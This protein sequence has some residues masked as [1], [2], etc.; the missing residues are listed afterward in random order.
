MKSTWFNSLYQEYQ[1]A[2]TDLRTKYK[3]QLIQEIIYN[4]KTDDNKLVKIFQDIAAENTALAEKAIPELK[5]QY[6]NDAA[7][8]YQ[9]VLKFIPGNLETYKKIEQIHSAMVKLCNG[10]INQLISI[11]SQS[12]LDK[13]SHKSKL[14][15]L[16]EETRTSFKQIESYKNAGNEEL[17][18]NKSAELFKEIARKMEQ[19]LGGLYQSAENMLDAVPCKYAVIGLG[20][21]ALRQMTP[22]SDLECAIL[23]SEDDP[24]H[25]EYFRN[26]SQL[27]HFMVINL[28]ETVI[29]TSRYGIDLGKFIPQAVN[30]DL[31]GKT[32]LG[33]LEKDKPYELIQTVEEM[34]KYLKNDGNK[35]EHIDKNLAAV[36]QKVCFIYGEKSLVENYQTKVKEFLLLPDESGKLNCESRAIKALWEGVEELDYT[37]SSPLPK[38]IEGNLKQFGFEPHEATGKLFDVKQEIYRL[39]DRL[40]YNLGLLYGIQEESSWDTI[41]KLCELGKISPG[42]LVNLKKALTFATNLRLKTYDHYGCQKE[43]I[44]FSNAYNTPNP[45]SEESRAALIKTF[46]LADYDLLPDGSLFEY[47]YTI[48]PFH[49]ELVQYCEDRNPLNFINKGFYEKSNKTKAEVYHRLGQL[50]ASLECRKSY[51][52]ELKENGQAISKEMV[53]TLYKIGMLHI[54][55]SKPRPASDSFEEALKMSCVLPG[56]KYK[57]YASLQNSFGTAKYLLGDYSNALKHHT[58]ALT[59]HQK[60]LGSNHAKIAEIYNNIGLCHLRLREHE[61]CIKAFNDAYRIFNNCKDVTGEAKTLD[62]IGVYYR[63]VGQYKEALDTH[64]K[65]LKIYEEIYSKPMCATVLFNL[66][67]DYDKLSNFKDAL[68]YKFRAVNL[69]KTLKGKI[70]DIAI[71]KALIADTYN[72]LGNYQKELK[73]RKE[74]LD[75]FEKHHKE[76]DLLTLEYKKEIICMYAFLGKYSKALTKVKE[77]LSFAQ[78]TPDKNSALI[79][80]CRNVMVNL[81]NKNN[82]YNQAKNALLEAEQVLEGIEQQSKMAAKSLFDKALSRLEQSTELFKESPDVLKLKALELLIKVYNGIGNAKN[83]EALATAEAE[84]KKL[85]TVIRDRE[86]KIKEVEEYIAL[87]FPSND[88]PKKAVDCLRIVSYNITVDFFDDRDKTADKHHHWQFRKPIVI[89]LLKTVYPDVICLQEL[90]PN[91]ALELHQYFDIKLGYSSVFLSQTPSEIPVGE[92]VSGNNVRQWCGKNIGTPLVGTFIGNNY[93]FLDTGRFWLNE[94]PDKLPEYFDR[95]ATDKGFGNMNTYRAVLWTKIEA[96]TNKIIFVFNSHYPLSGDSRTRLECVKL[97]MQKIKD[98]THGGNWISAGDRNIIP[99]NNDNELSNPSV[100][101]QELTKDAKNVKCKHYGI[102]TTWLGFSYDQYPAQVKDGTVESNA[103][104][105]VIASNLQQNSTFFLHGAFDPVDHNL[106]PLL[107]ALEVEQNTGRYFA[108]DHALAGADLLLE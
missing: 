102:N 15:V 22:Y 38:K 89:K 7:A 8:A 32:P 5:L 83:K 56:N 48:L 31:G 60:L 85:V 49:K 14:Q 30:F 68:Y 67:I 66:G 51:K 55:L 46:Q 33:R 1:K 99:T 35:S 10:S 4:T 73:Y 24:K 70:E 18:V 74:V 20:S 43:T 103:I 80:E 61:L 86:A 41:D 104:L 79:S 3:E 65:A 16:R 62:N 88:L 42:G 69:A 75:F 27:V 9:Y 84:Y 37:K 40:I 76:E 47:Y 58:I 82:I 63:E 11:N 97:E 105:D 77:V 106:L 91:Q 2:N 100:V 57:F 98:I 81:R 90:S 53:E 94:Q 54:S 93:K 50:E 101:L 45:K 78:R 25:R 36:L 92:I 34:L 72:K 12:D 39:P 95:G 26:L 19:Y 13:L 17:Y 71:Y 87:K 64:H 108:S 6:Y 29:P 107:G 23:I 52:S 59:Q 28:G 44:D 96:P 21:M